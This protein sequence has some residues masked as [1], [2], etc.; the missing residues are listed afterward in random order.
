MAKCGNENPHAVAPGAGSCIKPADHN[1]G[2][3]REQNHSNGF[4]EWTQKQGGKK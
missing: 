3:G 1:K 4:S 2:K